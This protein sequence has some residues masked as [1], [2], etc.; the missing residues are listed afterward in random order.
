MT[1][2]GRAIVVF[3]AA[4]EDFWQARP[5]HHGCVVAAAFYSA[6]RGGPGFDTQLDSKLSS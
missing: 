2:I 3:M 1:Y 4:S 5:P 6:S